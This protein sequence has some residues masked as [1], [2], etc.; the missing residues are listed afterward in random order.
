VWAALEPTFVFAGQ[1]KVENNN[2]PKVIGETQQYLR[3]FSRITAE[4]TTAAGIVAWMVER[5]P[6]WDNVPSQSAGSG[7]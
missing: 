5:Y 4:E 3:D 2:D 6:D 1:K 7:Y